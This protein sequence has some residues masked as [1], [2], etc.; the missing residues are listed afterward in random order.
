MV[1]WF[2]DHG[3]DPTAGGGPGSSMLD[4]AAANSS[5]DI[6]DLLISYGAKLSE[7]DALHS[8][9]GYVKVAGEERV[10]MMEHLL[11]LG[12]EINAIERRKFPPGRKKGQ[13]TPLH[14]AV[15]AQT[16]K[17]ILLLLEK[18]ADRKIVNTLGQTPLE[19]A[20]AHDKHFAAEC[21]KQE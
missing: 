6:L 10:K 4:V 13:G 15:Y 7:S 12:M 20:I 21:L 16:T 2:L 9:A 1:Q 18:G 19:Y 5:T 8:A 14:S 3:A 11:N 17:R